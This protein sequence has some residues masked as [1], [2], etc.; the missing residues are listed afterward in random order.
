MT[1]SNIN[2]IAGSIAFNTLTGYLCAK[3]LKTFEYFV[4][5]GSSFKL[6][7]I[8]NSHSKFLLVTRLMISNQFFYEIEANLNVCFWWL[9]L[10]VMV[11]I[12]HDD[13]EINC[14]DLLV[15][16]LLVSED[17]GKSKI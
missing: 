6:L 1:L 16:M 10:C 8:E 15:A 11:K 2:W 12:I 13:M 17:F 5:V 9:V 7:Q 4:I 3:V 14:I